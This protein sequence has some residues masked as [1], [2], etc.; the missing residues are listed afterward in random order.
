VS[1]TKVIELS[2]YPQIVLVGSDLTPSSGV[3]LNTPAYPTWWDP[4]G[5]D[6][7]RVRWFAR[8]DV[9]LGKDGDDQAMVV[10]RTLAAF[11]EVTKETLPG[12]WTEFVD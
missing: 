10:A 5:L 8:P 7:L 12:D 6:G 3:T 4:D 9:L 2:R 11:E 1:H